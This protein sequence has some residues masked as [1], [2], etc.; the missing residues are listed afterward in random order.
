MHQIYQNDIDNW[1]VNGTDYLAKEVIDV[2][3]QQPVGF[4]NWHPRVRVKAK[5]RPHIPER[6]R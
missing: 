6:Y 5:S 4:I 2:P 1:Y 3:L